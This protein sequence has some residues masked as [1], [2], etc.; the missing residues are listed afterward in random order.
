MNKYAGHTVWTRCYGCVCVCVR[1][2]I[3]NNVK[4]ELCHTLPIAAY[5]DA[6]WAMKLPLLRKDL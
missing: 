6:V 4:E 3:V 1:A 5:G 2:I